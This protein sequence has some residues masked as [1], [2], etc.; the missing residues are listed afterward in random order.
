MKLVIV[1]CAFIGHVY[2]A[3]SPC[4]NSC[5][6]IGDSTVK[7]SESSQSY[8]AQN[9]FTG[10]N[11]ARDLHQSLINE[12]HNMHRVDLTSTRPGNWTE[13][14]EYVTDNG[15]GS[16]HEERGQ[17]VG[18]ASKVN[19]YKKNYASSHGSD[20]S[21]INNNAAKSSLLNDYSN[22]HST[23]DR[24]KTQNYHNQQ[25][26]SHSINHSTRDSSSI[27]NLSRLENLGEQ[28]DTRIYGDFDSRV[29]SN[30]D[31]GWTR[32]K[33][34]ATDGGHGK[35]Y[36][37]EGRYSQGPAQVHYYK[38]NYTSS[39]STGNG[40]MNI[41]KIPNI[42]IITIPNFNTNIGTQIDALKSQLEQM[43]SNLNHQTQHLSPNIDNQYRPPNYISRNPN[44]QNNY[45]QINPIPL[46]NHHI[47]PITHVQST[48][49]HHQIEK[50]VYAPMTSI[51]SQLN[52]HPKY[53]HQP[54]E[55][56]EPYL[57]RE[58]ERKL[59]KQL[60][61]HSD[62]IH[63]HDD[64][65][66]S[67]LQNQ[68]LNI[69]DDLHGN[70]YSQHFEKISAVHPQV[71]RHVEQHWSASEHRT[72]S[73]IPQRH[74]AIGSHQG[75]THHQ[76]LDLLSQQQQQQYGSVIPGGY[77]NFNHA[78]S[79][80][81]ISGSSSSYQQNYG[82][83]IHRGNVHS[84]TLQNGHHGRDCDDATH[85]EYNPQYDRIRYKRKA[86]YLRRDGDLSQQTDE[87]FGKLEL[88]QLTENN[89]NPNQQTNQHNEYSDYSQQHSENLELDQQQSTHGFEDYTQQHSGNLELDQQHQSQRGQIEIG[90]QA[91]SHEYPERSY[92]QYRNS[93]GHVD[94]DSV[95]QS[96]QGFED[97]TQQ[98]T[99]NL[100]LDQQHTQQYQDGIRGSHES[101][102]FVQQHSGSFELDQQH[103]S[104]YGRLE[105]GQ[106]T[107]DHG[108]YNQ[109]NGQQHESQIDEHNY[110]LSQQTQRDQSLIEQSS[111]RNHFGQ[112]QSDDLTQQTGNI[113]DYSQQ[114]FGNVEYGQPQIENNHDLSRINEQYDY[115]LSKPAPKPAPRSQRI[116][117]H[118][119]GEMQIEPSP[120]GVKGGRRR[121]PEHYGDFNS[122]YSQSSDKNSEG[123]LSLEQQ[124]KKDESINV[125]QPRILEA[126][127][128]NGPYD[129][130]HNENIYTDIKPNPTA[131]LAPIVDGKDPW[132]V[133]EVSKNDFFAKNGEA[134]SIITETSTKL[135]PDDF[136]TT[137]APGFWKKLGNKITS[138]YEKAKDKVSD[139]F[140]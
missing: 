15:A 23:V 98:H 47:A 61:Q 93:N 68:H 54:Y 10:E 22:T 45:G 13:H 107:E 99:G 110:D 9:I 125:F 78:K 139:V 4:I 119:Q 14:N 97:Y 137:V 105:L 33:T 117:Q 132:D 42:P 77:D 49:T 76:N 25:H 113:R 128:G 30:P 94:Q 72:L 43:N 131:T 55:F 135:Y 121:G 71:D 12:L 1:L 133:R 122:H 17:L 64:S 62:G 80:D 102:D 59:Q 8:Q 127:G 88:G 108:Q 28:T 48:N 73:S 26:K 3:P 136:V 50:E 60:H 18:N 24:A 70:L 84:E 96:S 46:Q 87:T 44:T 118:S 35:V 67:H 53:H 126:Y 65:R 16:V 111:G 39:F 109:L 114:T 120:I 123:V 56:R 6:P 69:N 134:E 2:S 51:N 91:E 115:G 63:I 124:I 58:E 81:Y 37:E 89:Y 20:V 106:Q 74:S 140:G 40:N 112:Q 129:S 138:T 11:A 7:Q 79:N 100:H 34:Y 92:D 103:Q 82:T 116:G 32:Q 38:K 101:G 86:E 85:I 90:Q 75:I 41:P 19:Y 130:N 29:V 36:E 66:I 21:G 27:D 52:S 5:N 31:D 95:Q 104:Q 57:T 83:G